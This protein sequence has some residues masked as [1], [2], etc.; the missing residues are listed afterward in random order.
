[1]IGRLPPLSL[2]RTLKFWMF[3][4]LLC[5]FCYAATSMT[6]LVRVWDVSHTKSLVV[7][8][9]EG[10]TNC[11]IVEIS[12]GKLQLGRVDLFERQQ[13][14]D[15]VEQLNRSTSQHAVSPGPNSQGSPQ[16]KLQSDQYGGVRLT[17]IGEKKSHTVQMDAKAVKILS[18]SLSGSIDSLKN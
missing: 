11:L 13:V 15:L 2:A 17:I 14:R 18:E 16:W 1:M 4:L 7:Q 5:T 12:K 8:R 10:R 9:L 3:W 6:E